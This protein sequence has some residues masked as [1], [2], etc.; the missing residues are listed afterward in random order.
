M[1]A[2]GQRKPEVGYIQR[3][4]RVYEEL[5]KACEYWCIEECGKIAQEWAQLRDTDGQS[6]SDY[7]PMCCSCHQ[8]YDDHWDAKTRAKV[9]ESVKKTWD[10]NPSR[11][12]FSDEH[13]ANMREAWK[14]RKA[15]EKR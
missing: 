15:R 11:R 3:H 10:A 1:P 2:K 9:A 13:R 12:N 14:R 6:I 8:K 4:A 5:G 7:E